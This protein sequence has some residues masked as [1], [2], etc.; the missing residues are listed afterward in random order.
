MATGERRGEFVEGKLS[1]PHCAI[2]EM[3]E[4]DVARFLGLMFVFDICRIHDVWWIVDNWSLSRAEE[5]CRIMQW[6]NG[7]APE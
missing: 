6:E 5:Q 7:G 2:W 1:I 4:G 3:P